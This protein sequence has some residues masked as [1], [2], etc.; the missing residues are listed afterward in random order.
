VS[1]LD[2][3]H[4]QSGALASSRPSPAGGGGTAEAG[5][6]QRPGGSDDACATRSEADGERSAQEDVVATIAPLRERAFRWLWTAALVSNIGTWVHETG[7]GWLMTEI[8]PI[9]RRASLVG[10]VQTAATLPLFLLAIPAGALADLLDR[11]GLLLIAQVIMCASAT[12]LAFLAWY[13]VMTPFVLLF[14]TL[15]LGVGAAISNPAWQTG[16]VELVPRRELRS[17]ATLNSLSLN[18]SRAIG[19]TVG[20]VLVASQGAWAAFALNALS[21]LGIL[22]ALVL[23]PGYRARPS[24]PGERGLASAMAAGLRF[25]VRDQTLRGVLVRTVS[26][27]VFASSLWALLPVIARDRLGLGAAGYGV[28]L[29]SLGFGAVL[30]ALVLPRLQAALGTTRLLV[31]GSLLYAAVL[32]TLATVLIM[33]VAIAG[34]SLAGG[35]W[36]VC[37][38]CLNSTAQASPPAQIRGRAFSCYLSA[39]FGSMMLGG[40]LWGALADRAGI[41]AALLAAAGGLVGGLITVARFRLDDPRKKGECVQRD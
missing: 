29:G 15:A 7:A 24:A 19:P 5:L 1:G 3:E 12:A 2:T 9:D 16:M 31:A 23:W 25:V 8:A 39:F 4:L 20:G 40:V 27:A 21:F 22:A 35:A 26:F 11:R 32:V 41:R 38:V 6:G 34:M 10:L 33:P 30:T 28:L 17:A 14:G 13:D 36:I 18:L 37:V